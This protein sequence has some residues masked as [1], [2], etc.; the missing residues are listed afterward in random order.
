MR[1]ELGRIDEKLLIIST[2]ASS[3]ND[4][5]YLVLGREVSVLSVVSSFFLFEDDFYI[6]Q[7]LKKR[8]YYFSRK[9]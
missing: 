9:L 5:L 6:T 7:R 2:D 3:C 1:F 8:E 4:L